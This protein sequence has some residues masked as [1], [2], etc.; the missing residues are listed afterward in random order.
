MSHAPPL[1]WA[2]TLFVAA[3]LFV[4]GA[5]AFAQDGLSATSGARL[6]LVAADGRDCTRSV[7]AA[8]LDCAPLLVPANASPTDTRYGRGWTCDYS[9]KEVGDACAL[10]VPPSNAHLGPYGDRWTCD[11]GYR[12]VGDI[13]AQIVVPTNAWLTE[14]VLG[15][16]WECD[17]GFRATADSCA[18]V[19]VPANGYLMDS[20]YGSGW[21]CERGYRPVENRCAAVMVPE[22]AHLD[23]TGDSW[24]CHPRYRE[25]GDACELR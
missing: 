15:T 16:G 20:T 23:R 2:I 5:G 19:E 25:V 6:S 14:Y 18:A 1:S 10:V 7:G 11:R 9:F 3:A 21:K 17:R 8:A 22:N 12:P 24:D 13:C 4:F